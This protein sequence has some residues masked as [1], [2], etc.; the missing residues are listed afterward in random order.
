MVQTCNLKG[1]EMNGRCKGEAKHLLLRYRDRLNESVSHCIIPLIVCFAQD[2]TI[3]LW[4][5]WWLVSS[6]ISFVTSAAH[7]PIS[8][9]F[10]EA[11]L[12]SG[13]ASS[14]SSIALMHL[15]RLSVSETHFWILEPSRV[16]FSFFF[17][18]L[19]TRLRSFS[20]L[21]SLFFISPIFFLSLSPE[22]VGRYSQ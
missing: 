14:L 17:S 11:A 7:H 9:F 16:C 2:G 5:C 19:Q 1:F 20:P 12:L 15:V 3:V 8:L 22:I 6:T 13:F 21:N 4:I 10:L 18:P